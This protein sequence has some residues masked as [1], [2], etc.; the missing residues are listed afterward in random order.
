MHDRIAHAADE[1]ATLLKALSIRRGCFSFCA[2][3]SK[4]SGSHVSELEERASSRR[5]AS[6]SGGSA[7]LPGGGVWFQPRATLCIRT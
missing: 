7:R 4:A 1:A 5:P 6:A 3:W 2:S